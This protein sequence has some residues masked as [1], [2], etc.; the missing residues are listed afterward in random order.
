MG[1]HV[2]NEFA[3]KDRVSG[4]QGCEFIEVLFVALAAEDEEGAG[5]AGGDCSEES[6]FV[7]FGFTAS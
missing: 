6:G 1:C 5:V 7:A 4:V 3:D 2:L